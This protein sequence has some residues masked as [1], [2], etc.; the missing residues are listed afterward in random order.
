MSQQIKPSENLLCPSSILKPGTSL[1]GVVNTEGTVDYL[2]EAI[3]VDSTFVDEAKKGRTPEAR[4]R[5]AGNCAKS[6]CGQWDKEG[7]QCSLV[8]RIVDALDRPIQAKLQDCAIRSG[9]R[10]FAQQGSLACA[11]CNE[12]MRNIEVDISNTKIVT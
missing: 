3:K 1:F 5:F 9:C 10:W 12:V 6:G 4:F 2:P 7:H 8:G 11:N